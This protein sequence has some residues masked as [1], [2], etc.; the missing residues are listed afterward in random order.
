MVD[1][2]TFFGSLILA[3]LAGLWFTSLKMREIANQ[4]AA[5][6]CDQRHY[7]LLDGTVSLN[8]IRLKRKKR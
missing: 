2:S 1:P 8:G 7:Q 5:R 3:G 4:L 6:F